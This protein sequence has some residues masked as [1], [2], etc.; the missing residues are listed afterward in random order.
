MSTSHNGVTLISDVQANIP[1]YNDPYVD[2]WLNLFST[3]TICD[4][5]DTER[6]SSTSFECDTSMVE[7]TH[8]DVSID[9]EC[10][11]VADAV[12]NDLV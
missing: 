11:L 2:S 12:V 3:E 4:H 5:Q 1:G 8:A 9:P 7:T 10:N 6:P